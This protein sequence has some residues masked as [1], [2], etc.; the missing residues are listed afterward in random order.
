MRTFQKYRYESL[1]IVLLAA[2][3]VLGFYL[4]MADSDANLARSSLFTAFVADGVALYFIIRKKSV[5]LRTSA[6][7]YLIKSYH[8][9]GEMSISSRIFFCALSSILPT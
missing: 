2:L 9:D 5:H 4:V 8:K 1:A 6:Y 3:L 7:F